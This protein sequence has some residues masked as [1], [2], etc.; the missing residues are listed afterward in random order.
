MDI[1]MCQLFLVTPSKFWSAVPSGQGKQN[2]CDQMSHTCYVTKWLLLSL[3]VKYIPL[4]Y[5]VG[6]A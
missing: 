3:A 2:L 5:A 4:W 6:S 1:N